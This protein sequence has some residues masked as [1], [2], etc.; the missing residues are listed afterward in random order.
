MKNINISNCDFSYCNLSYTSLNGIDFSTC[1]IT[2]ITLFPNDIK[3]AILN[4]IQA[5]E[6]IKLLGIVIKK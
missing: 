2:G 5:L 4:D 1:N 3:G 6:F